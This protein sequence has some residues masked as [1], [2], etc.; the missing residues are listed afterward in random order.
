MIRAKSR[1]KSSMS[2]YSLSVYIFFPP[3]FSAIEDSRDEG[4]PLVF[5]NSMVP[6]LSVILH[7]SWGLIFV[8]TILV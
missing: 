1:T 5:A 7:V 2:P 3:L 4:I 8:Q 6:P